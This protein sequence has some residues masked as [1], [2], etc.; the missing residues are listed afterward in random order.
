LPH[1]SRSISQRC[2]LGLGYEFFP[3][4]IKGVE[5][6]EIMLTKIKFYYKI[7][8]KN[9]IFKTEDNMPVGRKKYGKNTKFLH[10]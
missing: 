7:L 10:P 5:Q 2:G 9:F 1:G 6:T 4:L 8:T 3:F